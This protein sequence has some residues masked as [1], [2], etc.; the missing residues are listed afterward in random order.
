MPGPLLVLTA[1]MTCP[2]PPGKVTPVTTDVRVKATG[3]PVLTAVDQ[4]PIVGC[5]LSASQPPNPCVSVQWATPAGRVRV[6]G[7]PALLQTSGG[8]CLSAA[9]P[10]GPATIAVNQTRAVGT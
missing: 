5:A 2:H 6:Q 1:Q 9:G 4:F 8:T 3:A 7:T 10:A